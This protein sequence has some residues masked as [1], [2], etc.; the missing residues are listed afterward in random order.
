MLK[1]C[2]SS[3]RFLDCKN[4]IIDK[5]KGKN[6]ALAKIENNFNIYRISRVEYFLNCMP[7]EIIWCA[8]EL[9]GTILQLYIGHA[10][11]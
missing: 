11:E 2:L 1:N 9:M 3:K 4:A 8:V 10:T 6:D 5:M 7:Q